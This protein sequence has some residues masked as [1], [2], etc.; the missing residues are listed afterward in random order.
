MELQEHF[1]LPSE[2]VQAPSLDTNPEETWDREFLRSKSF[3]QAW[4]GQT[5]RAEQSR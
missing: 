4:R 3:K 2:S 1:K 5:D